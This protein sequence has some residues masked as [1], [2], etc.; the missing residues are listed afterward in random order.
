MVIHENSITH[1]A[2]L[3]NHPQEQYTHPPF[4][5]CKLQYFPFFDVLEYMQHYLIWLFFLSLHR[6]ADLF[7]L[8]PIAW[9]P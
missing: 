7:H 4:F 1:S 5:T 2:H 3:Q 6:M 9:A 8:S